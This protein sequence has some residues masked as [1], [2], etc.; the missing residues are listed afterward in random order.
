MPGK[1][2]R[3]WPVDELA[4]D[5]SDA[6]PAEA[7][8]SAPTSSSSTS[9][10]DRFRAR[11]R[12]DPV[13]V[14]TLDEDVTLHPVSIEESVAIRQKYELA[15]ARCDRAYDEPC[16]EQDVERKRITAALS[17]DCFRAVR[18]TIAV[19]QADGS[20]TEDP[21]WQDLTDEEVDY[22]FEVCADSPDF[23]LA[24]MR[25]ARISQFER[26]AKLFTD[27]IRP[28]KSQDGSRRPSTDS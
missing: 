13:V 1:P 28:T 19:A 3:G 8:P 26:A 15:L 22:L 2:T 16:A 9:A 18:P 6:P 10:L 17:R 25:L 21:A 14:H 7:A 4:A 23:F 27:A 24:V 5:C 20:V 12:L 11:R